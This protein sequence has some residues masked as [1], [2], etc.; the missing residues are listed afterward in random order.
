MLTIP[1]LCLRILD[2]SLSKRARE[3]NILLGQAKDLLYQYLDVC[4]EWHVYPEIFHNDEIKYSGIQLDD[5]HGTIE[6]TAIGE[7]SVDALELWW[8]LY[9]KNE[10]GTINNTQRIEE[11]YT[12]TFLNDQKKYTASS[13]AIPDSLAKE[14]SQIKDKY[15]KNDRLEKYLY[16]NLQRYFTHIDYHYDKRVHFLKVTLTEYK[17]LRQK[18]EVYHGKR[19]TAIS[20]MFECNFLLPQTLRLG[21]STALGYGNVTHL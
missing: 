18:L 7:R 17:M 20:V 3:K 12:P 2:K 6:W 15:V 4:T 5:Y 10:E 19:K 16:G 13:L 21:Q 1:I 8:R 14:L 11:L 9:S